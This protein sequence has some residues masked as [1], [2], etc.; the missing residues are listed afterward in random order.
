VE[1]MTHLKANN[2]FEQYKFDD[3]QKGMFGGFEQPVD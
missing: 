2:P 1:E 3:V